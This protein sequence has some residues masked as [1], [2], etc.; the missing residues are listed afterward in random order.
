MGFCREFI[1]IDYIRLYV[2]AIKAYREQSIR[3][4]LEKQLKRPRIY[5]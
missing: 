1:Q 2:E 4:M 5:A 3:L